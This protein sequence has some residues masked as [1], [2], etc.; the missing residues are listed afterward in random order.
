MSWTS[1]RGRKQ[2]H[3]ITRPKLKAREHETNTPFMTEKWINFTWLRLPRQPDSVPCSFRTC[4][5]VASVGKCRYRQPKMPPANCRQPPF[6]YVMLQPVRPWPVQPLATRLHS[7]DH[8][9]SRAR[10]SDAH[11]KPTQGGQAATAFE[12]AAACDSI[13]VLV[14]R[15]ASAPH[16]HMLLKVAVGEWATSSAHQVAPIRFPLSR[17]R[18]LASLQFFANFLVNIFGI[19]TLETIREVS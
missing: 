3:N 9:L 16:N 7:R 19:S 5:R 8:L 4:W 15:L 12:L 14:A 10:S 17:A 13:D 1:K 2:R 18:L 11:R 6:D